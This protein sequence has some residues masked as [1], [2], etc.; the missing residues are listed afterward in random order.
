MTRLTTV[1]QLRAD[2]ASC[3]CWNWD[4]GGFAVPGTCT[5]NFSEYLAECGI[6]HC[7]PCKAR[8]KIESDA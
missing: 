6:P 4:I 5:K 7:P 2:L 3:R 8:E 1:K